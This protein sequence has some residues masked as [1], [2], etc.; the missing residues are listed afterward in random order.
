MAGLFDLLNTVIGKI[1]QNSVTY[2]TAP[3]PPV[4]DDSTK[5]A[6][7]AYVQDAVPSIP[8]GNV[9]VWSRGFTV[10]SAGSYTCR[11]F[12]PSGGTWFC[13]GKIDFNGGYSGTNATWETVGSVVSGGA[14]LGSTG[15]D[16]AYTPK[17]ETIV[18]NIISIII[19]NIFIFF[20]ILFPFYNFNLYIIFLLTYFIILLLSFIYHLP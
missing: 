15:G 17:K 4:G 14:S 3:T 11:L 1:T 18:I 20:I 2:A 9:A 8:S 13:W 7:T 10:S 12:A 6:T 5:V 16:P 19:V